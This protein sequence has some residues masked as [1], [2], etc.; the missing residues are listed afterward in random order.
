MKVEALLGHAT[1][2][3]EV[4]LNLREKKRQEN[5]PDSED[6]KS[7]LRKGAKVCAFRV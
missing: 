2:A 7:Q 3:T 1:V 5:N 6:R 4:T